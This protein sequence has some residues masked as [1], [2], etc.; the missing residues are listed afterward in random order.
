[1]KVDL[2]VHTKASDGSFSTEE[3]V[4][5]ALERKIE[6][7]SVTDHDTVEGI[8]DVP[9]KEGVIFIPGVEIS[10]EYPRT[11]HI[12]GYRVDPSHPQLRKTLQDL[13]NFRMER[14]RMMI[15][16][17]NRM[18][19]QITMEELLEEAGGEL[20]GRLHFAHLM[21]KK[22]YVSSYQ[23]AFDRYLA[24]G[25]P[26]YMDKKRLQPDKAIELIV[27]AGGIPVLA[28]PYQS[29]EDEERLEQLVRRLVD[30]GLRGIEAFYSQHSSE[31]TAFYLK[32]A[33]KY[34]LLVT[35]GTDF[36][37]ENKPDIPFGIEVGYWYLKDFLKEI[38]GRC[39]L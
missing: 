10:A 15:E 36:H 26:L 16:K 38:D 27:A 25:K 7:I 30:Y 12:L 32:L 4:D 2:H 29:E 9:R 22:G 31:Q 6:V 8:Q 17:M 20:I 33:K 34:D 39:V 3:L 35:A 24:K 5:M 13:Q 11:L 21:V 14:N 18:G 37:G 28:H 19:F 1:M 23:E